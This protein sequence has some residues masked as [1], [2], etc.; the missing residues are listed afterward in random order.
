MSLSKKSKKNIDESSHVNP[1]MSG[2]LTINDAIENTSDL[3]D[4]NSNIVDAVVKIGGSTL[5]DHDTTIND[6]VKLHKQGKKIVVIHGG[7]KVVS[8]WMK[9]QGIRPKFVE[10]LRVT[11]IKSL[12]IVVA[13][14]TG[15]INKQLV[16]EM[17]AKGGKA[18]GMS[19]VDGGMILSSVSNPELGYVG[20]VK[21][22]NPRPIID[23]L[24]SGYMPIISPIG[25]NQESVTNVKNIS[26][27]LNIN[28]DTVAGYISAA[29]KS[30]RMIFLTDVQGVLDSSK[31]LITRLTTQQ[32]ESLV[33]S[34]IIAGGMIP[35]LEACL[36][37]TDEG[38]L[39]QIIDGR[40]PEALK[41]AIDGNNL[42]TKIG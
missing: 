33:R 6:L 41:N 16:S 24:E 21:N 20:N 9:K 3:I 7:G 37:A 23:V 15:L 28:A 22:V 14:L 12:E 25:L 17:N 5:G 10:G 35:K 38:A 13:V 32:A 42:G 1:E 18:I 26:S 2:H 34:K 19:G 30:K 36:K 29:L 8:D 27:M 11:D 39:A 31:R 40:E 4:S